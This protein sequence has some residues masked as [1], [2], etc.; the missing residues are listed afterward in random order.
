MPIKKVLIYYRHFGMTLGGGEYLPLALIVELQKYCDV[1]LALDWTEH[2]DRAVKLFN[3][4]LNRS[5][6]SIVKLMTKNNR[7]DSGNSW[8]TILRFWRLKKLAKN[9]DIC[10]SCANIMNFGKPA[11]HFL[12]SVDLGDP[13]FASYMRNQFLPKKRSPLSVL[14]GFVDSV[15]RRML[16]MRTRR[17]LICDLREHIYPNSKYVESL[18]QGYYKHFN[19]LVFYPPTV[20]DIPSHLSLERNPLKVIYLG[21]ISLQKRLLDIIMIVDI[22][23]RLSGKNITLSIG[24]RL[25]YDQQELERHI[26]DLDW[27]DFPGELYGDEKT[28]FLLSGTYAIHAM[29]TEAFGISITEYLKARLIP[30][31]PDEG[32]ACEVVDDHELTFHTNDE[33]AAILVKL[34]DDSDFRERKRVKC[35]E[36]AKIFSKD[37]YLKRQH[38]LL[39][40]IIES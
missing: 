24:G 35:A 17:E 37:A 25:D 38:K 6:L 11:H 9:A 8:L 33:A 18:M 3:M 14:R 1:T 27:I 23:R 26:A 40:E 29:R 21:R 31:V 10:I 4:P 34:L 15:L 2:F 28:K 39:N 7:I 30:I 36:R 22:A 32:G 12:M 5:R 13:E 20:F 16:G 19:S